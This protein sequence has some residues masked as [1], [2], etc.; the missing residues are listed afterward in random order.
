M[1]MAKL[2]K[3]PHQRWPS[4]VLSA[5]LCLLLLASISASVSAQQSQE[6]IEEEALLKTLNTGW[7]TAAELNTD[8][9][10]RGVA[11]ALTPVI[12]AKIRRR[13]RY[14]GSDGIEKLLNTIRNNYRPNYRLRVSLLKYGPC[15]QHFEQFASLLN[16]KITVLPSMLIRKDGRSGYTAGLKLV[17]EEQLSNL[18]LLEA[19]QYWQT[20][21][22]LQ[23]LQGTCVSK[24]NDVYVISL[25][26]LGDLHG[27]LNEAIRIEFK[28][29]PNEYGETRDIHSLLILYSLAK[30]AQLRGVSKDLIIAYLSEALGIASQI[31]SNNQPGLPSIRAAILSMLNELGASDLT[32]MP[33]P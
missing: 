1:A 31:K 2:F 14:L 21:R 32:V 11:F 12:E 9:S 13:G 28:V 22:S 19:N 5:L 27:P 18:S 8:L 26:F 23:L 33:A 30:E 16:S 4:A 6:P 17:K 15:G 24:G 10:S 3:A 29:D 20:T 7:L 25:V